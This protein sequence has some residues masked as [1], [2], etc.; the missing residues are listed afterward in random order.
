VSLQRLVVP[1][2]ADL[3]SYFE[4]DILGGV[5][6][7]HGQVLVEDDADWDGQLYRSQP[8][9]LQSGAI[10]AIPYYAWDNRQ[11]GEMRVWLRDG[12]S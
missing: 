5:T 12:G 8:V 6:V 11:P 4:P 2:T 3:T 7:I 1:R 9:S 10:T